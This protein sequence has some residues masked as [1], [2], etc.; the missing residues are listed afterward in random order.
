MISESF[1]CYKYRFD[2]GHINFEAAA[3]TPIYIW[4]THAAVVALM[5]MYWI[6]LR[7]KPGHTIKYP[8][9]VGDGY[10]KAKSSNEGLAKE[11]KKKSAKV[12]DS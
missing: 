12:Q 4:G 1:V 10:I 11:G 7:F 8:L 5:Y 6:Y 3:N 2:T 9:D